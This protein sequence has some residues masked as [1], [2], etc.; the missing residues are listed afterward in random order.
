MGALQPNAVTFA[1]TTEP[2]GLVGRNG[3]PPYSI[4]WR[5][6]HSRE[7]SAQYCKRKLKFAAQPN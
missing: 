7:D 4:L 6:Y 5:I 1:T 3:I 2:M